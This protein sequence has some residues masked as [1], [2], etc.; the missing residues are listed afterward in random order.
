[1]WSGD[2]GLGLESEN[3]GLGFEELGLGLEVCGRDLVLTVLV[4]A[5][6]SWSL[7]LV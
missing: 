6:R 7:I 3:C 1:M 5:V 4:L 2:H